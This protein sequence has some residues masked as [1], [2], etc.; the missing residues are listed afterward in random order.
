MMKKTFG[1]MTSKTNGISELRGGYNM[2][3]ALIKDIDVNAAF[4][5]DTIKEQANKTKSVKIIE[6]ITYSR[7][8]SS[9]GLSFNLSD[10]CEKLSYGIEPHVYVFECYYNLNIRILDNKGAVQAENMFPHAILCEMR[11][12]FVHTDILNTGKPSEFIGDLNNLINQ[13][14]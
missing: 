10:I 6:D 8:T 1:E 12:P 7:S 4:V 3:A 14:R 2:K 11:L 13:L 5:A 9:Y